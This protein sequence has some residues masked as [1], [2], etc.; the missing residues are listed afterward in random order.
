[1]TKLKRFIWNGLLVTA[2]SLIMR[3]VGVAY[4]VYLSNSIGAV[5]MGLFTLISTV[6]G[7]AITLATSGIGLA[8]TRLVAEALGTEADSEIKEKSPAVLCTV[9]KC[10]VY[11]LIFSMGAATLLFFLAPVIGALALEDSRTVLPLRLLA[12][13]LPPIALSSVLSGYFV[14]VR[15]VH[16]NAMTQIIGQGVKIYGCVLF[17]G[18]FQKQSVEGAC[19]A[20]ALSGVLSEAVSVLLQWLLYRMEKSQKNRGGLP[21]EQKQAIQKNLLSTALPV[22]FSAYVRSGLIT[23]EHML[24]PKGLERSGASRDLSLAAY[25]TVHSMVFPLILFPSALSGSFAGLLIPE[26][27]EAMTAKNTARIER[28]IGRVFS[29][30]LTYAIGTAGILICFSSP[31]AEVIYPNTDAGKY[32]LMT[33]PLVPVM[34]LD[35]SVD[36]LLKGLGQQFYCMVVNIADSLLSVILVWLLLPR[37]GI[38]GYII[39]VYFTEI[40]NATLSI[41]RL[42]CVAR[43]K[44][45]WG[46]WLIRPLI[47][48]LLA[49]G[50]CHFLIERWSITITSAPCLSVQLILCASLYLLGIMSFH[51]KRSGRVQR[52]HAPPVA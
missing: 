20:V 25:G 34:Y 3:M 12:L 51:K 13:S 28:I 30:V 14:A 40:V 38:T 37:M 1:M 26:V 42:L 8:T 21:Q 47:C 32:I 18:L 50:V 48:I 9:K 43:V 23:I 45:K 39:T 15:R 6:Y 35:T 4:N 41:T 36:A 29:C 2:V 17:L 11:A 10:T 31:L 46:Q 7:F 16:K 52:H 33:A 44:I 24:I 27:T 49:T 5:A 19:I 22:A